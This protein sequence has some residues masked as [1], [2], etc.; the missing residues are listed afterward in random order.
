M[1]T[2]GKK[3]DKRENREYL[4]I[5]DWIKDWILLP[6]EKYNVNGHWEN[7]S[8]E[9]REKIMNTTKLS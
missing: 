3:K 7:K 4:K 8:E 9:Q 2:E 6:L 1:R 5:K